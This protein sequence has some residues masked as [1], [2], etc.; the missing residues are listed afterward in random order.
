MTDTRTS[1]IA[2]KLDILFSQAQTHISQIPSVPGHACRYHMQEITGILLHTY[3]SQFFYK[4]QWSRWKGSP[5][6]PGDRYWKLGRHKSD[7]RA[8]ISGN[9]IWYDALSPRLDL[10]LSIFSYG[11]EKHRTVFFDAC[12]SVLKLLPYIWENIHVKKRVAGF[13]SQS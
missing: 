11:N 4:N 3:T 10:L 7:H 5:S 8:E 1:M 12:V 2:L 9:F 13:S 6:L